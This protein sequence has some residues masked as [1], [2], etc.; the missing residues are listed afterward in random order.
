MALPLILRQPQRVE[1]TEI[2]NFILP[3]S[4]RSAVSANV[5]SKGPGAAIWRQCGNL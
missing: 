2:V 5:L 3:D 1:Q 4:V